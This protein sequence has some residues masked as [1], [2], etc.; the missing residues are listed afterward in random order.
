[1]MKKDR[2]LTG[3]LIGI[4]ALVVLALVL[5]FLRRDDQDYRAG[6]NPEAVVYN[7]ILAIVN[8]DYERAYS[9]L[10]DLPAK[11][12]Y[13]EFRQS[14]LGGMVNPDE[15][16]A[17]IGQADISGEQA[18]VL[19]TIYYGYGGP[20]SSRSGMQ[21]R[22]VLVEQPDGW[23]VSSMPYTYWDFSWYQDPNNPMYKP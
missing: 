11:P 22:A 15:A 8:K 19:L 4:A 17:D 7:Y 9:Y 5:F 21:E 12:S 2:F 23:K 13:D 18:T 10:A 14:F 16:G 1:M 6:N 3:I 20:F